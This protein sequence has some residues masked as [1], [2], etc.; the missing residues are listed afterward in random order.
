MTEKLIDSY[1][2]VI[3]EKLKQ[4]LS[5][6]TSALDERELVLKELKELVAKIKSCS[7]I[8]WIL[9]ENIEDLIGNESENNERQPNDT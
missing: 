1:T 8:S 7:Q 3:K 6:E 2:N 5:Q 9:D 4:T